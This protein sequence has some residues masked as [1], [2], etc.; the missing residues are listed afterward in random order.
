MSRFWPDSGLGAFVYGTAIGAAGLYVFRVFGGTYQ[1]ERSLGPALLAM[2]SVYI[3]LT[4]WRNRYIEH[5]TP[6]GGGEA[7]AGSGRSTARTVIGFIFVMLLIVL[8]QSCLPERGRFRLRPRR[9]TTIPR[10]LTASG[11]LPTTLSDAW[12]GNRQWG[13]VGAGA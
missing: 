6:R 11:E 5:I 7:A 2:L 4:F 8:V 9:P 1:L 12:R 13:G 10:H 3:I